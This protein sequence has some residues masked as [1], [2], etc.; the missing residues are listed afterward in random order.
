MPKRQFELFGPAVE[1]TP[2]RVERKRRT[3]PGLKSSLDL[4][5]ES[6]GPNYKF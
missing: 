1:M 5:Q 6:A 3:N 4:F 2:K